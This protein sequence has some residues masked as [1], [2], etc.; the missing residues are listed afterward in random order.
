MNV[1]KKLK[2]Y[3]IK[4]FVDIIVY[5]DIYGLKKECVSVVNIGRNVVKEV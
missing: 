4:I 2:K 1:I 5:T 3:M